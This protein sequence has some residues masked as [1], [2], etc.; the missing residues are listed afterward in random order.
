M[1]LYFP[2]KEHF[3]VLSKRLNLG[4]FCGYPSYERLRNKRRFRELYQEQTRTACAAATTT[5]RRGPER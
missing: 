5:N 4:H 2:K 3:I 1:R